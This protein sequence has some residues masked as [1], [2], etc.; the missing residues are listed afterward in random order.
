MKRLVCLAL[1]FCGS[2]AEAQTT[3][4]EATFTV[5]KVVGAVG[6]PLNFT[7]NATYRSHGSDPDQS[8][9]PNTSLKV[10][11]KLVD[12]WTYTFATAASYEAFNRLEGLENSAF[13]PT[14]ESL[15]K[16]ITLAWHM[17]MPK[18]MTSSLINIREPFTY[19]RQV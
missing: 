3:T 1:F 7:N 2:V 19:S 16:I 17:P 18:S 6:L 10:D 14:I 8:L 12:R 11:G 5:D 9:S 4:K 15:E 13:S